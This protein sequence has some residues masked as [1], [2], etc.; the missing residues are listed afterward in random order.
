MCVNILLY[1][2]T[3]H[4]MKGGPNLRQQSAWLLMKVS[5]FAWEGF[6]LPM[7]DSNFN[8]YETT[9]AVIVQ[10]QCSQ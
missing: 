1:N 5:L 6:K 8:C 3:N 9:N 10:L 7:F 4:E 2:N